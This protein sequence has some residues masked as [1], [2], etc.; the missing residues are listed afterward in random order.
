MSTTPHFIILYDPHLQA[1]ADVKSTNPGT[2]LPLGG[3]NY[4][5]MLKGGADYSIP[6]TPV[7]FILVYSAV[8][9]SD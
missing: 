4:W 6:N 2:P 8:F 9:C 1:G 3:A 7:C 5:L